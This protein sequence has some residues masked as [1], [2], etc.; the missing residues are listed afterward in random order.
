LVS[1]PLHGSKGSKLRK[2]V[3]IMGEANFDV[4]EK[5]SITNFHKSCIL[6]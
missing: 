3:G 5:K 6:K 4:L 2:L 1:I